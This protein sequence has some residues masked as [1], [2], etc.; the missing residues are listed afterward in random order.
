MRMGPELQ[1]TAPNGGVSGFQLLTRLTRLK[2]LKDSHYF[3]PIPHHHTPAI[4][5]PDSL[6]PHHRPSCTETRFPSIQSTPCTLCLLPPLLP[7]SSPQHHS[8]SRPRPPTGQ[9]ANLHPHHLKT[10]TWPPAAANVL[11]NALEK[12]STAN[13]AEQVSSSATEVALAVAVSS[14]APSLYAMPTG[15]QSTLQM[16]RTAITRKYPSTASQILRAKQIR[17]LLSPS[18]LSNVDWHAYAISRVAAS[19]PVSR[20]SMRGWSN[21]APVMTS[22]TRLVG[23]SLFPGTRY[24]TTRQNYLSMTTTTHTRPFLSS[25][26]H[27]SSRVNP[28]IDPR[29]EITRIRNSLL[30]IENHINRAGPGGGSGGASI[31]TNALLTRSESSSDEGGSGHSRRGSMEVNNVMGSYGSQSISPTSLTSEAGSGGMVLR[32][33]DD[34]PPGPDSPEKEVETPFIGAT[35]IA[36]SL[37]ILSAFVSDRAAFSLMSNGRRPRPLTHAPF[38]LFPPSPI[39]SRTIASPKQYRRKPTQFETMPHTVP[40]FSFAYSKPYPRATLI[41]ERFSQCLCCGLSQPHPNHHYR[42]PLTL[43]HFLT[44]PHFTL[45]FPDRTT[46]GAR[47]FLRHAAFLS[48]GP[49]LSLSTFLDPPGLRR[50]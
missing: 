26:I 17:L 38:T 1:R 2:R 36:S 35:S 27:N 24:D 45:Q 19:P 8:P 46:P 11:Q 37:R 30:V 6:P 43:S 48:P 28:R 44:S 39:A 20:R 33:P 18:Y 29:A 15:D 23:C 7:Q 9:S 31:A 5:S 40:F 12:Q 41:C 49:H 47:I 21:L 3:N 50:H 25:Q 13:H 16:T 34:P 42:T 32:L 22:K 10:P 4:Y 14:E